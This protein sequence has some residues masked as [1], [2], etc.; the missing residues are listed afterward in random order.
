[1]EPNNIKI[2]LN[3]P[4]L[5]PEEINANKRFKT[6]YES[7]IQRPT[8]KRF[9]NRKYFGGLLLVL[10]ITTVLVVDWHEEKEKKIVAVKN[11]NTTVAFINKPFK[12]LD[13]PFSEYEI[14]AEKGDTIYHKTGSILVFPANS[15]LDKYG[16]IAK[17]HV[18]IMYKEFL[19]PIDFFVSGIP[20]NYDSSGVK[21]VFESSGMCEIKA[22]QKNEPLF[23]NKEL[24]PTINMISQ[25]KDS[26]HNLYYLDTIAKTW[27]NKGKSKITIL[28]NETR[29]D[30]D[31]EVEL[32][33]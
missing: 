14:I 30:L 2:N 24:A 22:S 10:A 6:V 12:T 18:K 23:V 25:N 21:Y 32:T 16:N 8:Y 27:V 19:D 26:K 7:V 9:I 11:N 17:G 15:L 4:E 13:I 1:M 28:S 20:M 33:S 5:T 29:P 3:R 31:D